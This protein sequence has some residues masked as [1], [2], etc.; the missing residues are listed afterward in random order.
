MRENENLHRHALTV[1]GTLTKLIDEGFEDFELFE[2]TLKKIVDVHK[3]LPV[4]VG[5]RD[6]RRL[7]DVIEETLLEAL[8]RHRTL[9]LASSLKA[10]FDV[11]VK[12]FE[13]ERTEEVVTEAA[14]G[15]N[16]IIKEP[17]VASRT[18]SENGGSEE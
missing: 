1:F 5:Q 13:E 3:V 11:I 17:S 7:V 12:G 18:K 16:E 15:S 9:T 14:G 6:V 8:K 2:D 4:P 10:F